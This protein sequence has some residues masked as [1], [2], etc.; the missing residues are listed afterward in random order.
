MK[1]FKLV[2]KWNPNDNAKT[3]KGFVNV[4]M[5]VSQKSGA[6]LKLKFKGTAIGFFGV[7]G[8]AAGKIKY[9]IDNGNW[10]VIDTVI[11]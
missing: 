8:P 4:P 10:K 7:S 9:K 2:E 6:S 3:R 1:D 5:L 11:K